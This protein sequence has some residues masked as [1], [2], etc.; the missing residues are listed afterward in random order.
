VVA[1]IVVAALLVVVGC[2][3][4]PLDPRMN[5]PPTG[6]AGQGAAPDPVPATDLAAALKELAGPDQLLI[7]GTNS[8]VV[9]PIST[10]GPFTAFVNDP[11]TLVEAAAAA[12]MPVCS[13]EFHALALGET[14]GDVITVPDALDTCLKED[15]QD[16]LARLG[17][18]QTSSTVVVIASNA[19]ITVHS[20]NGGINFFYDTDIVRLLHAARKLYVP[21][22]EVMPQALALPTPPAG[23]TPGL[24]VDEA[25]ASCGRS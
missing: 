10:P 23:Q 21:V 19:A 25:L 22:C 16:M 9:T 11:E 6:A 5:P 15:L 12:R 3:V 24:S 18:L 4:R 13:V 20:T 1:R 17:S 14:V 2:G 7:V 8:G